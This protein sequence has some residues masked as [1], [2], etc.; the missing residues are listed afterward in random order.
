MKNPFEEI[1]ED[2]ELPS[3]LKKRVMADIY[4]IKFI[5]DISDLTLV[6]YPSVLED[7]CS[8]YQKTKRKNKKGK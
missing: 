5:I 4:T 7:L 1:F 2:E 8:R 6:K 3:K